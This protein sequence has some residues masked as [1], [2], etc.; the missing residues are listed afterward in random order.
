MAKRLFDLI[1]SLFV[2]VLISPFF[3]II[4]VLVRLS[5][6]GAI[7]YAPMIFGKNKKRFRVLKFR[8]MVQNADKIG[9]PSTAFEDRRLTKIG[10]FLRRY[11]LDELPQLINVIKGDMSVVGP[12]PQVDEYTSRYTGEEELI[13]N[14]KPGMTDW[15]TIE[16][17]TLDKILGNED[18]DA[19][20]RTKI[21][22][23]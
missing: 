5:S 21:E 9:G 18:V 8:T 10:K 2:L 20:Y 14:V 16:F 4:A 11:K 12:R 13:L 19:K 17:I 1:S 23:K 3:L 7:F 22:P 6:P 15:A